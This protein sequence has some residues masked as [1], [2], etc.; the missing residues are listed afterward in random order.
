MSKKSH[1]TVV[2]E[3]T[4]N[5]EFE[6]MAKELHERII[7]ED[8]LGWRVVAMANDHEIARI[9]LIEEAVEAEYSSDESLEAVREYLSQQISV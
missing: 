7:S 5:A 8:T 4:D 9:E 1:V 6:D 2:F 3:I